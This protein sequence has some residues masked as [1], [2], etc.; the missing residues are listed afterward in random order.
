MQSTTPT[1]TATLGLGAPQ[2][3][4]GPPGRQLAVLQQQRQQQQQ[5]QR[6]V[7][8][9]VSHRCS[10]SSSSSSS[11]ISP[12]SSL[13][14]ALSPPPIPQMEQ[15]QQQQEQQQ[16][17]QQQQRWLPLEANPD[18]LQPYLEALGGPREGPPST[19]GGGG[20]SLLRFEDVVCLEP[21]AFDMLEC[22]DTVA[23]L[24]LFPLLKET[25][26]QERKMLPMPELQQQHD[27]ELQWA[28]A[29]VAAAGAATTAAADATAAAAA[30][31]LSS[32]TVPN[33]CGTVAL[34]HCA[35]NLDKDKFPLPTDGFIATFLKETAGLDGASRGAALEASSRLAA[36]HVSHQERGQ[37]AAAAAADTDSH[38][39][40]LIPWKGFVVEL[41]GRK[42][43]PIIRAKFE[44]PQ[45]FAQAAAEV[46]QEQFVKP[47][48]EDMHFAVLA[49]GDARSARS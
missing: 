43:K 31:L 45:T 11:S 8:F 16:Q 10:S 19:T 38:F 47:R 25:D 24:L 36:L 9:E 44:H 23:L 46:I 35:A 34:L 42:E 49:V 21:W 13:F 20:S 4:W 30:V 7:V 41:D 32:Q 33:A 14:P 1:T 6:I 12:I 2:P 17:E 27:N 3:P 18:V 15:Q 29:A 48:G 39:S 28:A 26:E 37:T 40:C 5:Q 22:T